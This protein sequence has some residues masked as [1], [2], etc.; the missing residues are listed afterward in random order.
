MKKSMRINHLCTSSL[1]VLI[2]CLVFWSFVFTGCA[3]HPPEPCLKEGRIYGLTDDWIISQDWDSCYRRA[4]SYAQGGCREQA[5][6]QFLQAIRQRPDD[7]WRAR[8]YGMHVLNEYFPHRE[9]GLLYLQQDDLK[10]AIREL[11][12]SLSSADS[13]KAKYYLNQARRRWL[14][15]TG[16]DH[17]PPGFRFPW[18]GARKVE[19]VSDSEAFSESKEIG[20]SEAVGDSEK[21][22]ESEAAGES[23]EVEESGMIYTNSSAYQIN[24]QAV[25]DFF[26]SSILVDDQPLFLDLAQ[27]AISFKKEVALK[28]GLNRFPMKVI[29]LVGRTYQEEVLIFL[30]QQGPTVIF[31]PAHF[32]ER[33][34]EHLAERPGPGSSSSVKQVPGGGGMRIRGL[35]FDDGGLA[36]LT[37]AGED[38]PLVRGLRMKEFQVETSSLLSAAGRATFWAADLAGNITSGDL[39]W[40]EDRKDRGDREDREDRVHR[41]DREGREYREEHREHGENTGQPVMVADNSPF[42]PLPVK[43]EL[44]GASQKAPEIFISEFPSIV[45]QPRAVIQGWIE[46]TREITGL[47]INE[48][49]VFTSHDAAGL[50]QTLRRLWYGERTLFYFTRLIDG[51]KEGE[52]RLTIRAHDKEGRSASKD[53]M[54]EYHIR[55]IDRIGNRWC[56]AILPFTGQ[57]NEPPFL[58]DPLPASFTSLHDGLHLSFFRTGRFSLVERGRID[59]VMRELELQSSEAVDRTSGPR[60]GN[61]LAAEV[62]L[63]G[64]FREEW[65]GRD[66]CMEIIARLVDVETSRELA[67]KS[68]YNRWKSSQDEKYLLSGLAQ[69]FQQEFPLSQGKVLDKNRQTFQISMCSA[70]LIKQGMKVLVFRPTEDSPKDLYEGGSQQGKNRH[71][72]GHP[73]PEGKARQIILGEARI[74]E[75]ADYFSLAQPSLEGLLKTIRIGDLVVTK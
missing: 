56:L 16:M 73:P 35:I 49:P 54:M 3:L 52:N 44:S 27:P 41:E 5:M 60:L 69:V 12:I 70:D 15:K 51:L 23:E 55:E 64:S 28:P 58:A 33:P 26:V 50:F 65:D 17:F 18:Q 8:T 13:A 59:A 38:I 66:R 48:Q 22:E 53:I 61:L 47:W 71:E 9:L 2:L 45:F 68:V 37:V 57:A 74:E 29:D 34:P 46:S 19:A 39:S 11:S 40:I 36:R 10:E 21:I 75:V 25:D 1:C 7:Q 32:P 20:E 31:S 24:G 63:M 14:E 42:L 67:V 43:G 6:D 72:G 30:D 4:I 62:L